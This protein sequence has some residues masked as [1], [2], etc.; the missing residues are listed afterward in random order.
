MQLDKY[1]DFRFV[2]ETARNIEE[3]LKLAFL[4]GTAIQRQAE[5]VTAE[6]IRTMSLE[7][8]KTLGGAYSVFSKEFQ[9]SYVKRKIALLEKEGALKPLP[10]KSIRIAVIT[11][12]NA[13][14]RAQEGNRLQLW[15]GNL[16]Q[17]LGP[18]EPLKYIHCLLY[19]S[20]SPRDRTRSR[21]PSSA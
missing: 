17:I 13:L 19:T 12:L 3:R 14:G 6:E 8:D 16:T 18:V 1:P 2:A 20:P 5:R 15:L 21:M 7:L 9:L 10:E 4:D 11:G